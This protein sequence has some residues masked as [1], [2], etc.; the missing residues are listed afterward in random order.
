MGPSEGVGR[1]FHRRFFGSGCA[2]VI[3]LFEAKNK[4][5]YKF[6]CNCLLLTSTFLKM[7]LPYGELRIPLFDLS[8]LSFS[9]DE[10]TN[11]YLIEENIFFVVRAWLTFDLKIC[12]FLNEKKFAF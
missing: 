7:S 5:F 10:L 6:S 1:R 3:C 2:K 9:H 12:S 8:L 11:E 4:S